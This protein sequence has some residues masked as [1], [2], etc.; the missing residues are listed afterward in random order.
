MSFDEMWRQA[1]EGMPHPADL[2]LYASMVVILFLCLYIILKDG[3]RKDIMTRAER[4]AYVKEKIE[5]A[6]SHALDELCE[7]GI[8][9]F[10]ERYHWTK[11]IA[12]RCSLPGL[13][14]RPQ[15]VQGQ[16]DLHKRQA[17]SGLPKM[18]EPPYKE[19]I[20]ENYTVMKI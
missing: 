13:M 8:I 6:L 16:I 14:P 12:W 19:P 1:L 7:Q 9:T 3:R 11:V 5:D 20:D 18:E 15:T 2:G 10:D 17:K 4:K